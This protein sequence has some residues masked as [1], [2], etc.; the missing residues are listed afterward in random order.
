[1]C[2]VMTWD[3]MG[4]RED[5][6]HILCVMMKRGYDPRWGGEER[7][8]GEG[9]MTTRNGSWKMAL[10][11]SLTHSLSLSLTSLSLSIL[12]TALCSLL[13]S[14]MTQLVK[15]TNE[16]AAAAAAATAVV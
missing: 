11:L 8:R 2:S 1:M 14:T 6:L 16:Q 13:R 7:G 5:F 4:F 9:G 10:S 3:G 12:L 15:L